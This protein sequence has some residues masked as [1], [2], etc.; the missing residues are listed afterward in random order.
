MRR[1]VIA[2]LALSGAAADFGPGDLFARSAAAP[3]GRSE[4]SGS[5]AALSKDGR[6]RRTEACGFR[7]RSGQRGGG[8][9]RDSGVVSLWGG[10]MR[11]IQRR[12]SGCRPR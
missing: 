5:Q 3:P 4:T 6:Q 10:E 1:L 12:V 2:S 11:A 7:R 9:V 8:A